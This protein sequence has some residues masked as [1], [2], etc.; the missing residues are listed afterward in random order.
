MKILILLV[1]S[2]LSGILGRMGGAKGYDT[3][4]RDVGCPL[5][6][7]IALWLLVDFKSSYW[8]T[9]L[10]ILGLHW[11][12]F[13]TYWNWLFKEDNLWF[14][15]FAVGLAIS[16]LLFNWSVVIRAI[17][18]A[19]IWGSLNKY[20]PSAGISG[21]KRILLWRRDVVEEFLRYFSI[22]LTLILLVR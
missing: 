3:K 15:G 19:L 2:I 17:L 16:L 6:A 12:L 21:D 11:V 8:W 14:S 9:Y 1:L 13:S 18:L 5:I 4:W 10:L 7:L 22:P 20:L